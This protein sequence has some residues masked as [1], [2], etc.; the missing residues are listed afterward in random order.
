[1]TPTT[2][3]IRPLSQ[4]ELAEIK[5][6]IE[7]ATPGPWKIWN[8]W[9]P[10]GAT[11]FWAANRIGPESPHGGRVLRA[12]ELGDVYAT[13]EDFEFIARAREDIPRLVVEVERLQQASITLI[14]A[15]PC[16]SVMD[17]I[18]CPHCVARAALYGLVRSA[19]ATK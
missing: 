14:E 8:G 1:M 6:R 13:V 7:K 10:V 17:E 18:D 3:E 2:N 5:A 4:G 15:E 16:T 19:E 9:G 12:Q 11:E